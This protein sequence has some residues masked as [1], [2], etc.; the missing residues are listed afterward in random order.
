MNARPSLTGNQLWCIRM[1]L[2]ESQAKF[3]KRLDVNQVRVLRLESRKSDDLSVPDPNEF[4]H[5]ALDAAKQCGIPVPT[6]EEAD[7][8]RAR[9]EAD[10]RQKA[11][12]A[13]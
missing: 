5:L 10:Q 11:E 4:I 8:Q 13:A 6:A 12:D 1:A 9:F 3:G 2:S 7:E